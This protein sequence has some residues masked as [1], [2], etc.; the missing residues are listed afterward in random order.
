MLAELQA[1]KEKYRAVG[2]VRGSGLL[3]GMEL[4]EDRQS[5]RSRST[6]SVT[7]DLYQECLRR[8]LVP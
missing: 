2:E 5:A 3:L 6:R 4:V 7:R 8:G 1:M